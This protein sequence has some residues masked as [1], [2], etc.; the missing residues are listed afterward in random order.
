MSQAALG[1]AYALGAFGLWGLS[2]LYWRQLAHVPAFE[3]LLHRAIW[4]ALLMALGVRRRSGELRRA[5][6]HRPTVL[7]LLSTTALVG[8]NWFLY[9]RA[10]EDHRLL[11]AS[12]GYYITPLLNV[13]LGVAVL[14]ERLRPLQGVAAALAL[15]GVLWLV[16]LHGHLPWLALSL[17]GTFALYSLLRKAASVDALIGLSFETLI[18][19]IPAALIVCWLAGRGR[20]VPDA[21]TW[22]LLAGGA[23]VTALPLL[24]FVEAAR[25]LDLK[26]LGFLQFSS[27]TFQFLIAFLVFGEPLPKER[28]L[29]FALI[30]GAVALYCADAALRSR[31]KA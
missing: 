1:L 29:S 20:A 13:L 18:L 10:I 6:K 17:A 7:V 9:I 14:G 31:P 21:R 2:P 8:V 28:F 27:P 24:W 3:I 19:A 23:G 11:D 25:R 4:S 22:L 30:W 12:L 5:F 26:T 15:G 16:K